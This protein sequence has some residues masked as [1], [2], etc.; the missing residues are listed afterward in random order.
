MQC[1]K[2]KIRFGETRGPV[3][4][5]VDYNNLKYEKDWNRAQFDVLNK[6]LFKKI[7][8]SIENFNETNDLNNNPVD[9]VLLVGWSCWM[10]QIQAMLKDIYGVQAIHEEIDHDVVAKGAAIQAAIVAEMLDGKMKKT[11]WWTS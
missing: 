6:K 3:K 7:G 5:K 9:M 4:I 11:N 10:P 8:N 1:E 2:A